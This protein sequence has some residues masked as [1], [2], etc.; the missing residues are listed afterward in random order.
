MRWVSIGF[1]F[2][3]GCGVKFGDGGGGSGGGAAKPTD[4]SADAITGV[5]CGRDA[6]TGQQLCSGVSSCPGLLIDPDVFPGCGFVPGSM[7]I[8]CLCNEEV[9]CPMGT[10]KSCADAVKLLQD[11]NLLLVCSQA[12]EPICKPVA[13]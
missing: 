10:P 3:W 12:S 4:A 1:V 8:S 2:A 7:S 9:L 5:A 6:V 13:R 11:S